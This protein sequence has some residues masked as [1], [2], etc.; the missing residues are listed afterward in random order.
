MVDRTTQEQF[1]KITIKYKK[2][3][4]IQA[5]T[6]YSQ[7]LQ[8]FIIKIDLRAVPKTQY[9]HIQNITLTFSNHAH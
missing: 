6:T 3:P 4:F 1:T 9:N 8:Q 7:F 2:L 5:F